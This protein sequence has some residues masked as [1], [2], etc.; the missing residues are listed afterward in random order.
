MRQWSSDSALSRLFADVVFVEFNGREQIN[1][2]VSHP[3]LPLTITAHE[4]HHLRFFDNNTGMSPI[5]HIAGTQ[6]VPLPC[7]TSVGPTVANWLITLALS[8]GKCNAM[9]CLSVCPVS[10]NLRG[11]ACDM[12]GIHF[13]QK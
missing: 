9:V 8:G 4:D 11:A 5:W 7:S 3:T 10:H 13:T 1:R 12:T 6:D 2:I